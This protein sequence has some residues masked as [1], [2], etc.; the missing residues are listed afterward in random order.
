S[1]E[2]YADIT[3]QAVEKISLSRIFVVGHSLGGAVGLVA[4]AGLDNLAHFVSVEGNLVAQD[5][6]LV[7]RSLAAQPVEEFRTSGFAEF[8]HGLR[9]SARRDLRVW[10]EWFAS[11]DP[12]AI[13]QAAGS[14]VGWSDSGKLMEIFAGLPQKSYIYGDQDDRLGYLLPTLRCI[15]QRAILGADHFPMVD[16]PAAFYRALAELCGETGF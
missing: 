3:R 6:G 7:S 13:H 9:D 10:A 15:P 2:A 16:E 11:G 4:C 12:T 8:L 14:L 1:I 5:C